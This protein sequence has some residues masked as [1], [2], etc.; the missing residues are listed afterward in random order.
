MIYL[1]S[2]THQVLKICIIS[3]CFYIALSIKNPKIYKALGR[4]A[5]ENFRH[6]H[7]QQSK[8]LSWV[9]HLLGDALAVGEP[10]SEYLFN[11]LCGCIPRLVEDGSGSDSGLSTYSNHDKDPWRTP[12]PEVFI[13]VIL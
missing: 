2:M 1:F 3:I 5:N 11:V 10:T 7:L 12:R 6:C 8:Q 9:M 4:Q 13:F